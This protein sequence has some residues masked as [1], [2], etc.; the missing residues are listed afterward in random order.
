MTTHFLPMRVQTHFFQSLSTNLNS[1]WLVPSSQTTVP[2]QRK[3]HFF[4]G[5]ITNHSVQRTPYTENSSLQISNH[6]NE[7]VALLYL[8]LKVLGKIQPA[9]FLASIRLRAVFSK[10]QVIE[11]LTARESFQRVQIYAQ[12]LFVENKKQ[13]P[14]T[15]I[16]HSNV[17][18]CYYNNK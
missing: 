8:K 10:M 13:V 5:A 7:L 17:F 15:Y 18:R 12:I 14:H 9:V 4:H 2:T 16:S 6:C 3:V 1:Y 11:F